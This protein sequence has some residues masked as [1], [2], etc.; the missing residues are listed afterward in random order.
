MGGEISQ[1]TGG[2]RAC[3]RESPH[4]ECA[5]VAF[6][7]NIKCVPVGTQHR[8]AVLTG[9]V[10]HIGMLSRSR[11]IHPDIAR[12]RRGVV[13]APF[14]LESFDIMVEHL[15][16]V[17]AE[18]RHLRRGA[19][20]LARLP[21]GYRHHVK[22]GH[23]SR[24]E[25]CRLRRVL[26]RSREIHIFPISGKCFGNLACRIEGQPFRRAAVGIHNKHIEIPVA[27][28]GKRDFRPVGA[29]HRVRFIT[30]QCC[31]PTCLPSGNRHRVDVT[32]ISK[33]NPVAFGRDSHIAHP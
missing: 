29:P 20:H 3:N 25:H 28:R 27:V 4:I 22:L 6:A 21:S 19:Q 8:V 17:L 10:G 23:T 7:E 14:I 5:A 12:H 26:Y 9:T 15:R 13:F 2:S 30:R 24:R 16:A 11:I 18:N 33:G 31:Q 1:R 32:F